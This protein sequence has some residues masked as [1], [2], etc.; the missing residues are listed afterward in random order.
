MLTRSPSAWRVVIGTPLY[1]GAT[2]ALFFSGLGFSAAAPQIARFLVDDLG[3]SL[4]MAG[5]Y[6]LTN[7]TALLAGFLVGRWSDRTGRRLGPFRIC[8]VAGFLGWLGIGLSTQLWMP[9]VISA[10]VLSFAGAATSQLFA[11]IHDELA[12]DH[13]S[14]SDGVV[15]YVRMSLTFGWVIGPVAGSFLAGTLGLRPMLVATA[16]CT[17]LQIL[18]LGTLRDRARRHREVFTPE[19]GTSSPEA[20]AGRPSVKPLLVFTGLYVLV[21]AGEPIK[22]AYLPIYMNDHHYAPG[23]SGAIIAIQPLV[24]LVLMPVAAIVARKMGMLHLMVVG[25]LLGFGANM[26]FAL[27]GSPLGLFAAQ[28][29]MGGVW[30]VFAGL[31]IIVAQ[32]LLPGAVATA[33]A[34]FISAPAVSS[35]LGGLVGGIG[36]AAAGLP[37]VF[38]APSAMA[39]IASA[40]LVVLQR[41]L[42]TGI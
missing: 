21:Y 22:Y 12:A 5:L 19:A 25:A 7:L 28:L 6:Y 27:S 39:L 35:A 36:V 30:G 16:V 40:G 2:T 26:L 17:L 24:E 14:I 18:P 4:T 10:V 31:G 38:L 32:R 23:L 33:S 42:G 15:S 8:A 34:I 3:G 37:L 11:A 29:L 20:R 41:R 9:F 13:S 1:R